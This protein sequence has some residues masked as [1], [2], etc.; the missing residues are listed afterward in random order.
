MLE[1]NLIQ[2]YKDWLKKIE[3]Q[4]FSGESKK[5]FKILDKLFDFKHNYKREGAIIT[6]TVVNENIIN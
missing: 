3:N 1:R 2:E 4:R 6:E 5:A